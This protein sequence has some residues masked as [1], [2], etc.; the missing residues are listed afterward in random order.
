[1]RSTIFRWAA[2]IMAIISFG[3][4]AYFAGKIYHTEQEYAEVMLFM[5]KS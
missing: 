4:A 2:I 5:R 3:I 1:M